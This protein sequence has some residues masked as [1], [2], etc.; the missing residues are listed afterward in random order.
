M[1]SRS[2]KRF[3]LKHHFKLIPDVLIIIFV[4]GF[5]LGILEGAL[6]I[7]NC[8]K[9]VVAGDFCCIDNNSNGICDSQENKSSIV[10]HA[11][12]QGDVVIV[13]GYSITET[14]NETDVSPGTTPTTIITT[15]TSTTTT[16]VEEINQT[17]DDGAK[18]AT[19]HCNNVELYIFRA[20]YNDG[21]ESNVE[22]LMRN[23]GAFD[24]KKFRIK[25]DDEENGLALQKRF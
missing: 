12:G 13:S 24:L 25:V 7:C 11:K 8:P 10:V 18:N 14:H 1:K 16:T 2:K 6:I 19:E 17:I 21:E 20:I 9:V 4:A 22:I 3:S 15:T 23:D 5:I